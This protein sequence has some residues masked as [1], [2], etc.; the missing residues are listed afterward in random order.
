[1]VVEATPKLQ[2]DTTGLK[3][4]AEDFRFDFLIQKLDWYGF[5]N[6]ILTS[7]L[8]IIQPNQIK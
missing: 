2:P 4:Q 8:E 6:V 5:R 7:F 3:C 1:M